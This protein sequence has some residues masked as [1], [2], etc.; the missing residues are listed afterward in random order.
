MTI[1]LTRAARP[2]VLARAGW[3][4]LGLLSVGVGGV[5][6][7]VPGLPT[8]GPLVREYRARLGIP[9]RAKAAAV[10]MIIVF[11]GV[12]VMLV[13]APTKKAVLEAKKSKP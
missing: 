8:L 1:D 10:V 11:A 12:S 5:G 9:R 3:T 7:I 2:G 6:I 4:T 13:A